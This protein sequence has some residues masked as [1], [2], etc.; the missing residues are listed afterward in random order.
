MRYVSK[1]MII[2]LL[3]AS[4]GMAATIEQNGI[5]ITTVSNIEGGYDLQVGKEIDTFAG[6]SG[7]VYYIVENT[8]DGDNTVD[9]SLASENGD[10]I[11]VNSID[12]IQA[13]AFTFPKY[14]KTCED[15]ETKE[16]NGTNHVCTISIDKQVPAVKYEWVN[17]ESL[18]NVKQDKKNKEWKGTGILI[19][20]GEKKYV[21]MEY[22]ISRSSFVKFDVIATLQDGVRVVLD[23]YLNSTLNFKRTNTLA[24]TN[25]EINFPYLI[26]DSNCVTVNNSVVKQCIWSVSNACSANNF[27]EY[28]GQADINS[29]NATQNERLPSCVSGGSAVNFSC[30]Q[31]WSRGNVSIAYT[32]EFVQNS[33]RDMAGSKNADTDI[34]APSGTEAGRIGQATIFNGLTAMSINNTFVSPDS[35]CFC[36]A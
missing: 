36:T 21:R 28:N 2:A 3:L 4:A 15:V 24:C 32:G 34:L 8:G 9:L 33:W 19:S 1:F 25:S 7:Y 31:V 6:V 5:K 16:K 14:K 20:P 13:T 30:A 22:S 17:V 35:S 12:V 27:I 10:R 26:N 18:G 11:S 29:V 23:P